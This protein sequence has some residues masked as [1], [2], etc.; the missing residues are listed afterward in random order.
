[1]QQKTFNRYTYK[2]YNIKAELKYGVP[3]EIQV[4]PGPI[5]VLHSECNIMLINQNCMEQQNLIN[6]Y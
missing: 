2:G 6:L 3:L 5:A 4:S 1:M